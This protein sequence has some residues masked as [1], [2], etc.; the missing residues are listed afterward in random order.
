MVGLTFDHLKHIS[1]VIQGFDKQRS[2][3]KIDIKSR[4]G[5][6]EDFDDFLGNKQGYI[7]Q[8]TPW[9]TWMHKMYLFL[10]RT[11]NALNIP[12]EDDKEL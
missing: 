2:P 5:E 11:T 1:M 10:Q 6:I 9:Q 3:G 12:Y 4:F 8:C 7:I